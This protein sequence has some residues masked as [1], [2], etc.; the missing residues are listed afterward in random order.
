MKRFSKNHTITHFDPQNN[1]A[2]YCDLEEKVT[3]EVH[4]CY[5]GQIDSEKIKR[6]DIDLSL[7]NLATG[8]IYVNQI[9]SGNFLCV[10]ILDIRFHPYGIMVTSP[11]LG[12]LGNHIKEPTTKLLP[13]SEGLVHLTENISFPIH[14][15]I[16][17]I[18]VAPLTDSIHC[19]IPG[20]H[21]GNMDT[22]DITI[23]SKVYFPTFHDGGLVAFGDMHAAMGD[24]ELDGTGVEIAGEIDLQFHKKLSSQSI[25]M[26]V[27]E[28]SDHWLFISSAKSYHDAIQMGL[29]E[30]VQHISS[31]NNLSFADAYRLLSATCDLKISQIVNQL[32]T[33]RI[34]VPKT[35]LPQLFYDEHV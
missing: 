25:S 33:I 8:P 4:D 24:G 7:M 18:G 23:G 6:P 14:P 29:E 16:G 30:T 10:E 1:P 5:G 3:V 32:L 34:A 31:F 11:G 21:G 20:A 2:Y 35:V 15:M 19:A 17:V 13:V 26:P 12:P 27:V 22:K 9:E 28:T